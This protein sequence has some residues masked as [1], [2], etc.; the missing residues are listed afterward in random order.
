[1][2]DEWEVDNGLDPENPDDGRLVITREGY[3][4]LEVYLNSLMG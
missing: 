3:T 4:A 2:A 1:M